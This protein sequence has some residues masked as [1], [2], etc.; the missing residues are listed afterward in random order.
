MAGCFRFRFTKKLPLDP[1]QSS[2][3][4]REPEEAQFNQCQDL[5]SQSEA[6]IVRNSP[7]KVAAEEGKNDLQNIVAGEGSTQIIIGHQTTAKDIFAGKNAVQILGN[8]CEGYRQSNNPEIT[9][10]QPPPPYSNIPSTQTK[11]SAG[12]DGGL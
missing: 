9:D 4:V 12:E 6:Q 7:V 2:G 3:I 1:P 8:F 10:K 11:S 5:S